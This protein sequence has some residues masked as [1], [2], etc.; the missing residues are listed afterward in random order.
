MLSDPPAALDVAL[1][2][3]GIVSGLSAGKGYIGAMPL[4]VIINSCFPLLISM[5]HN[6]VL[7]NSNRGP[8]F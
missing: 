6:T 5:C 7:R 8:P 1:G 3:E 2:K 4:L